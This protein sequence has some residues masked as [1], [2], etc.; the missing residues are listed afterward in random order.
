VACQRNRPGTSYVDQRADT[1]WL[2]SRT[3]CLVSHCS[4]GLLSRQLF[5]RVR[6]TDKLEISL[7]ASK[8]SSVKQHIPMQ[9]SP[10]SGAPGHGH[11]SICWLSLFE[12]LGVPMNRSASLYLLL[13]CASDQRP[14]RIN[15]RRTPC[16][17][18]QK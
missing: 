9:V 18:Q 4:T 2:R 11:G 15:A 12:Q 6:T 16:S 13:T 7:T 8:T 5:R 17:P 3:R 1:L 10:H 14:D